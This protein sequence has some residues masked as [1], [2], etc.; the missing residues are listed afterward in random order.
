MLLNSQIPPG[1]LQGST[2][3][4]DFKEPISRFK[5]PISRFKEPIS[6]FKEPISRLYVE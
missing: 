3:L 6:R 5:E 2:H 4:S 1:F